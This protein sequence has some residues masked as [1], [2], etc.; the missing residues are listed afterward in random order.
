MNN[1][2]PMNGVLADLMDKAGQTQAELAELV[3]MKNASRLSRLLGGLTELS[4]DEAR[5]I[6]A[7]IPSEEARAYGAYLEQKWTKTERPAFRHVSREHLRKA[8][9][10]L[11]RVAELECDPDLKNAFVKQIRSCREALER[12]AAQLRSTEHP[13]ALIGAP[14]VGKTSVICTLAE[15]RSGDKGEDLDMEMVLQTGGGR[16]TL[17]EVHVRNGGEFSISVEPCTPDELQA[18]VREFCDDLLAS[19]APEQGSGREG[20]GLS[21]EADRAIRNMTGLIVKRPKG[22]DGKTVSEDLALN[23]AKAFPKQEDLAVQVMMLLELPRR[24]R[25]SIS[26]PRESAQS[27]LEWVAETFAEINYGRHRDFSLPRRIEITVPKRLLGSNDFDLR[28]ID[29]RGIDEPTAPRRDLQAYLDDPRAVIVLCSG[30]K[31]APEAAVQSV[32]E[33]GIEAGLLQALLDKGM[34]L[35]LPAGG[36][37]GV[38]RDPATG[39]R[40]GSPAEGR[41]IRREQVTPTLQHCGFRQLPIQFANIRAP[42]DCEEL[43]LALV[44]RVSDMRKRWEAQVEFLI[45]TLDRLAANRE[46]EQ[47]RAVF[48]AATRDLRNWFTAN[49]GLPTTDA[50][51]Q[52]ALIE[53][54]D[55]VRYASS[56]RASVNRRGSW[57]KFDYWHGLGFGTRREAVARATKQVGELKVL[58][59]AV[60]R[61]ADLEVAHDFVRHFVNELD[62]TMAEFH[63]WS[64]LLGESAFQQKLGGDDGYWERC[65]GR[66]GGGPGYKTDISHWTSTWFG[67]EESKERSEFIEAALQ[68]Q[69]KE[70]LK[71]L[72][73]LL[74]SADGQAAGPA[75]GAESRDGVVVKSA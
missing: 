65:Q 74:S 63:Q 34:L 50:E 56:L 48:D 41:E 19:L 5:E 59:D 66:W 16:Q 32:L 6:A 1:H 26:F 10:A 68:R 39:R 13:V 14:G 46:D 31:D 75:K 4:V 53:E 38:L 3:G 45:G 23:L 28:L 7:K 40:V 61:D 11:Q 60:F 47:K 64:Q 9:E 29:T 22:P 21:S 15:L 73:T 49:T 51:V 62:K 71:R 44:N 8:E 2:E 52:S 25:T 42:E 69:W 36:E 54:I 37:D 70:L 57:H 55:G 18:Y 72:E 67:K 20:P 27:G 24:K 17:C 12:T 35:V 30:F 58:A 33:R 43:R